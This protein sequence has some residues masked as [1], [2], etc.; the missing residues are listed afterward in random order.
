MVPNFSEGFSREPAALLA[1]ALVLRKIMIVFVSVLK[2]TPGTLQYDT[3]NN[4]I[5]LM[6]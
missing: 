2:Y 5:K 1:D 4:V 3:M 6:Y